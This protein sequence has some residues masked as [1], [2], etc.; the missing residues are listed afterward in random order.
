MTRKFLF[1]TTLV[2]ALIGSNLSSLMAQDSAKR[3]ATIPFDFVFEDTRLPAG[4]Y[5]VELMSSGMIMLLN[6]KQPTIE[7][8]AATLPAPL[9][10]DP[11]EPELVFVTSSQGYALAEIHTGQELRV[12][13]SEYGHTRYSEQQLRR[14]TIASAADHSDA[15]VHQA[16]T[17]GR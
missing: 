4:T 15:S 10:G 13:T 8:E 2:V 1:A 3:T 16:S 17:Q 9:R 5:E 11:R 7:A 6:T 12:I 14:V